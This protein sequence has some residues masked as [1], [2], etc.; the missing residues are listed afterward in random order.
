MTPLLV[1]LGAAVGAP[2]RWALDRAVQSRHDSLFPWGTLIINVL[3]S[4]LLG[5]LLGAVTRGPAPVELLALV[6]TGFAGAF[7]TYST[8]AFETLRLYEQGA[9]VVAAANVAVSLAAGMAAAVA[10]WYLAVGI[11]DA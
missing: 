4:L 3:G 8:F 1:A 2:C 9:R 7:T 11:W 10:G 5:V 6:G